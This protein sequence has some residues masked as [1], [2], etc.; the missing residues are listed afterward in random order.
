MENHCSAACIIAPV[1]RNNLKP[2]HWFCMAADPGICS[3]VRPAARNLYPEKIS[4]RFQKGSLVLDT[5]SLYRNRSFVR[6]PVFTTAIL[7]V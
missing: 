5:S 3:S 1:F 4:A 2:D 7:S 6:Q